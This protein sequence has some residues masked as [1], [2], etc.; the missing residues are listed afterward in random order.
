MVIQGDN[1]ENARRGWFKLPVLGYLLKHVPRHMLKDLSEY[2]LK[3]LV[4]YMLKHVPEHMLRHMLDK[5][6]LEHVSRHV[7]KHMHQKMAPV[8]KRM[9]HAVLMT[10]RSSLPNDACCFDDLAAVYY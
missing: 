1:F 9:A 5:R 2:M 8:L 10:S 4:E 3:D 7:P 6:V